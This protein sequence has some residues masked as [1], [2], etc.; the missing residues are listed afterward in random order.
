MDKSEFFEKVGMSKADFKN[1]A[2]G[3][4]SKDKKIKL[5]L[6]TVRNI[7]SLGRILKFETV[8]KEKQA[9]SYYY[10]QAYELAYEICQLDQSYL[11]LATAGIV[12]SL[13]PLIFSW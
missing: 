3:K 5:K 9:L 12:G 6:S 11:P 8:A 13:V 10:G 4:L 7:I 1:F 2:N